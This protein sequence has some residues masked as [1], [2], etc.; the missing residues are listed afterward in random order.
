MQKL[1]ISCTV[2]T[3]MGGSRIFFL[4]VH[5]VELFVRSLIKPKAG[6]GFSA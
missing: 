5:V 3:L 1:T 2:Y 6:G 4:R